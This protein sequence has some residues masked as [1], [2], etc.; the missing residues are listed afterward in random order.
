MCFIQKYLFTSEHIEKLKYSKFDTGE[1][2]S[3]AKQP[4]EKPGNDEEKSPDR[5]VPKPRPRTY[6]LES[7]TTETAKDLY[8]TPQKEKKDDIDRSVYNVIFYLLVFS[9][10]CVLCKQ[11]IHSD[12]IALKIF[13][14]F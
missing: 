6:V 3:L 2:E 8:S 9:V 7:P 5:P 11:F 14:F 1:N 10:F 4:E 12:D 13:F